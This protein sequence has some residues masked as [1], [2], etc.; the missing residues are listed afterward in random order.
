MSGH[1]GIPG[2]GGSLG[3]CAV[4]DKSFVHEILFGMTCQSFRVPGME[5][6]LYAHDDCIKLL[7]DIRDNHAGDWARLPE[8]PLRRCYATA[9]ATRQP[10]MKPEVA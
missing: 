10:P 4:C 9:A 5:P 2:V 8:G 7:E 1:F 6:T 3:R